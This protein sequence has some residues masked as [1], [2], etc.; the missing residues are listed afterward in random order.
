MIASLLTDPAFA[1]ALMSSPTFVKT[2]AADAALFGAGLCAS[3]GLYQFVRFF[4]PAI[5][6][7]KSIHRDECGSALAA[8]LVLVMVPA[9]TIM[10]ILVQSL[11]LMRE[12]VIVHYAAFTAAR[13]A[14]VNICPSMPES[15]QAFTLQSM[16]KLGC[17]GDGGR[18]EQA[19][20][21]A[22]ISASPPWEV[23]CLGN[24]RIPEKTLRAIADETGTGD[25]YPALE[26]QARYAF[27]P[28]NVALSVGPDPKY[29]ALALKPG[30]TPPIRARLTFRHYV[31]YGL[32]RAFGQKRSDG[33]YYK[34]TVAEVT[35]L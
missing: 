18:A 27:D 2:L 4:R 21:L 30:L 31:I 24:C 9:I 33:Y 15:L 26:V 32:G 35:L 7:Q 14:R 22:L 17:R 6:S 5:R 29:L 3:L 34:E 12:T 19:A 20:R 23:P 13:S 25:L 10:L 11:W 8:D 1:N 28:Q 16:G